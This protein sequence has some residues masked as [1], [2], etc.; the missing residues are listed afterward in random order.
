MLLVT[1]NLSSINAFHL[2]KGKIFVKY[3]RLNY[4]FFFQDGM[5]KSVSI[6]CI[7]DSVEYKLLESAYD[8]TKWRLRILSRNVDEL[9]T[10]ASIAVTEKKG[11]YTCLL[12]LI[13]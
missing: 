10:K 7:I 8:K 1:I 12:N 3:D 9:V 4:F 6:P 13:S 11:S 5:T 2:D